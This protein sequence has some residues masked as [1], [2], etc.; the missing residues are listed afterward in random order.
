MKNTTVSIIREQIKWMEEAKSTH[1]TLPTYYN[2]KGMIR[3]AEK[4]NIL[5]EEEGDE[6]MQELKQAY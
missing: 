5:S 3:L 6:L 2:V 1:D 4:L